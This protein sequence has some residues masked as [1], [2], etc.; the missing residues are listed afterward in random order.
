MQTLNCRGKLLVLEQPVVMGI[1][2]ITADSFYAGSR[3]G[4]VDKALETAAQMLAEGATVLDIGGQSTRP[5][6]VQV[7][8]SDEIQRVVP[9][10]TA[11][12]QAFPDAF[13]SVDTYHAEVAKAAVE[14]GAVIVNDISGGIF[15]ES[16]LEIV[17]ALQTPYVCMHVRGTP[18]TMHAPMAKRSG[19]QVILDDLLRNVAACRQAGIKDIIL[20]PG[21][22]FSK[23]SAENLALVE[24]LDAFT[25]FGMPVLL[26]VSRKSTIYRTLG[27]S[28]EEALNG[29][30]VLHTIGLLKGAGILRAHDVKQAV[31]CI[32]LV[33]ALKKSGDPRVS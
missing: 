14:A 32:R 2:N 17:A 7:S 18:A 20:D 22:G 26:G 28:P 31:E 29:T 21:F 12:R 3:Q 1:L 13:L 24:G 16:M 19:L 9:V 5:G 4:S 33:I 8:A 15:D 27:I 6:A 30:T 10:I 11:I 25:H 23:Q